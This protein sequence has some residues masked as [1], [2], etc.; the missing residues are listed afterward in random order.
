M[1]FNDELN[2]F[3]NFTIQVLMITLH[4]NRINYKFAQKYHYYFI[5]SS[6]AAILMLKGCK[7][8]HFE[9]CS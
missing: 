9:N 2:K 3:V 5:I 6:L 1:P 4:L 8:E 7:T